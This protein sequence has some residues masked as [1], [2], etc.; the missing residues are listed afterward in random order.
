MPEHTDT[1]IKDRAKYTS[2]NYS[3]QLTRVRPLDRSLPAQT[4][5]IVIAHTSHERCQQTQTALNA[6][7]QINRLESN[8]LALLHQFQPVLTALD[9]GFAGLCKGVWGY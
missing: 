1:T 6:T 4:G 7:A 3:V 9:S 8:V 2:C 5:Y